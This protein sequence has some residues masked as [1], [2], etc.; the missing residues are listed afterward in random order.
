MLNGTYHFPSL[1]N[2]VTRLQEIF[3]SH[4]DI[5][6]VVIIVVVVLVLV[7]I[8]VENVFVFEILICGVVVVK[9]LKFD[10]IVVFMAATAGADASAPV[11]GIKIKY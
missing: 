3:A 11:E 9:V 5:I 7:V 6:L 8:V 4:G 2:H 1:L 10:G